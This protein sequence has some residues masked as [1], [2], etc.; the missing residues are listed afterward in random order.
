MHPKVTYFVRA[1]KNRFNPTHR[2]AHKAAE[3]AEE[4]RRSPS[5]KSGVKIK[6]ETNDPP[7]AARLIMITAVFIDTRDLI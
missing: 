3:V 5:A 7:P 1:L 4:A 6:V 2:R